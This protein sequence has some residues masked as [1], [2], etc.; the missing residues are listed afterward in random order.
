MRES[1]Q[2]AA[3][4]SLAER[5]VAIPSVSPDPEGEA[6]CARALLDTLPAGLERGTWPAADGRPIVHA[7]LRGRSPRTVLLLGHY[8]TV[9][10]SEFAA[11]DSR[12][13]APLAFDCSAL[14]AW[15][16]DP[17]HAASQ[18]EALARDLEE[19]RETPGT[20]MFGR[21]ALDMKG[22]L[23]AGVAAIDRLARERD[24]LEGGVLFVATPDEEHESAGMRAAVDAIA[25]LAT[26]QGLE[27]A[28]AINLDYVERPSAYSGVMGK[29]LAHVWALGVP[30]H[31]AAPLDGVD[32]IQLAAAVVARATRSR[33]LVDRWEHLH[34]APAVALR[35]RD[36]KSGYNLQTAAEA[37]AEINLVTFARPLAETMHQLREVAIEALDEWSRAMADLSRWAGRAA[38]SRGGFDPRSR[39]LTYPELLERAG[40]APDA[41][42]LGDGPRSG[43]T[44]ERLRERLN[45]LARAA[46]LA[47]PLV[48][49]SLLPPWYPAAAPRDGALERAAAAVLEHEGLDFRA[50]YPYVSDA[51]YLAWRADP[52][53][54]VARFMPALGREYRL[55]AAAAAALDLDVV[56]LGPWGRD[57]HG[58]FERVN[59]PY[60]FDRLP[61]LIEAV[62]REAW[63]R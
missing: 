46:K 31:A 57:A 14:R 24:A 40:F 7:S 1:P 38:A 27:L 41:D 23:A 20:W 52:A 42:P 5:L 6:R 2:A 8:D 43:D 35:L 3:A 56:T 28:G 13:D 29:A 25:R 59:A 9:G 19:E 37:V 63:K 58:L 26:E 4:R 50:F 34:G 49:L 36:L 33:A 54:T 62:V 17:A 22:G 30:T 18:P 16:L 53:E 10:V 47:G 21:G 60:A 51:A 15:L 55:P 39:V 45:H 61:G 44:R 12:A 11:I 48:V 32:A